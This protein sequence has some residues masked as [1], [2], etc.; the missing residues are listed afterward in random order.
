MVQRRAAAGH[1]QGCSAVGHAAGVA[2]G[3]LA[4]AVMAEGGL[5]RGQL[6]G[7]DLRAG[8]LVVLEAPSGRLAIGT[9]AGAWVRHVN[10]R[11]LPRQKTAVTARAR[12]LLAHQAPGVHVLAPVAE[13][14][15][16]VLGRVAHQLLGEGAAVDVVQPVHQ[17][18]GP[19][20]GAPTCAVRQIGHT[21]VVLT[22]GG[23][24][25][26]AVAGHDLLRG[27]DDGLR[28]GAAGAHHAECGTLLGQAGQQ[29]DLAADEQA[30]VVHRRGVAEDQVVHLRGRQ[31]G[32]LQASLH[33][34]HAHLVQRHVAQ[35]LAKVAKGRARARAEDDVVVFHG[36]TLSGGKCA[37][38]GSACKGVTV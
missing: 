13:A 9:L 18:G 35:G 32:A 20:P 3:H 25:D 27:A 10:G 26:L 11:D 36:R 7:R 16:Q 37:D 22:A 28:A 24:R 1:Q 33:H 31:S 30:V 4:L 6:L 34:M 14:R 2:R 19:A 23:H 21:R 29:G 17:R 8:E 38:T 15:G 5:E 12:A